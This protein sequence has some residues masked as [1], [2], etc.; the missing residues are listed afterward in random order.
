[1][2]YHLLEPLS[3]PHQLH[4]YLAGETVLGYKQDLEGQ[5]DGRDRRHRNMA[6]VAKGGDG[7]GIHLSLA[8]EPEGL[9]HTEEEVHIVGQDEEGR[10]WVKAGRHQ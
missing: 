5:A 3:T 1:M 9:V 7:G 4:G 6:Q 10:E 2:T 8:L